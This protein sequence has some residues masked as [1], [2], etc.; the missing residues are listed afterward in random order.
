MFKAITNKF[1]R[2]AIINFLIKENFR[3]I[4]IVLRVL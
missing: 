2:N 1:I 4:Y 3:D